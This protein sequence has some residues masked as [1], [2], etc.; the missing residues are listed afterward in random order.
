MQI[1]IDESVENESIGK[2][3]N[4][5]LNWLQRKLEEEMKKSSPIDYDAELDRLNQDL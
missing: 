1:K 2:H 5:F 4:D 3:Q